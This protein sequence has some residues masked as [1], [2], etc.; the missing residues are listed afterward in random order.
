MARRQGAVTQVALDRPESAWLPGG[1]GSPGPGR[2]T[3]RPAPCGAPTRH[4]RLT[5]HQRSDQTGA[6]CPCRFVPSVARGPGCV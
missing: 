3:S 6:V 2:E 5:P 1:P 4:L